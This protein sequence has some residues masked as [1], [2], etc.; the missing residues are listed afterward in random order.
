MADWNGGHG[1]YQMSLENLTKPES[2]EILE[3]MGT[4]HKD[5]SQL[6]GASISQIW[7]YLNVRIIKFSYEL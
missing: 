3:K 6:E 7:D 4:C 2:K 5:T 1:G